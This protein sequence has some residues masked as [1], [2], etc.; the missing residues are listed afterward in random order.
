[1]EASPARVI[2][3]FNGEKQNLIPLF[4]RPYTW[5]ENNWQALWDDLMVQYEVGDTGTHFMGAIVSV[6][7]RSTP[8]G[9]NKYLII[10][11]QQRLTTVSLLLCALRDCLDLN[12]ASRIQEVYLTNRFRDLEDTLKFVPTQADRDV[13]R[14]IALDRQVPENSKDVRMAAAYH[15]FKNKLLKSTDLNDDRVDPVKVLTTLEQCLQ[16][17]M[18]NLGDD[19]DPYLIFESLNFKGEPLTQ[20]DLVRN[21]LLM[22]FR[23]SISTGGEQERVYSKYWVPL[24]SRLKSNLTEFLR[25]YTMKDGDDIKQGGIYAAIRTKLKTMDSTEA[26]EAEVQSM[27]RFGEFYAKFLSSAPEETAIIRDRLENIKEIKVTT[28]YPLLLRLFDARQTG[29]LSD[30]EL[31]KCLGLVES[32]VVRRSVC[33]V[34]TNPLN[35]LF[36]QLAKNFPDTEHEQWLL[37]TLSSPGGNRRFPKDA[38]F[39]AAFM[40][41]PQYGRGTTRFILCRLEKSFNHKEVVDLSTATIEH[42]LPQTLNQAWKDELGEEP[43]TVHNTL[44][45]TFG[46]LT[47]TGYNSELGNLPFSEKKSK[48]DTTHIELNRWI[49]Q[50]TNWGRAEIQERAKNL[51]LTAI[52]IWVSPSD[53]TIDSNIVI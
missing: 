8:V 18:I 32:F 52:K 28:S 21:Y 40:N 33:G 4:Q 49:L 11:G 45:N 31:D 19:D 6:P 36:I 15:F 37:R 41:Q 51:L 38:E 29:A 9:V 13:Y 16:V 1:M 35:K 2:Q 46:N 25:H 43:E 22:R 34:P 48:L 53:T 12:S 44:V 14:T 26:I 30:I 39:A 50:Q 10:D 5:T 27:Q 17:V 3:Y 7:A 24:E 42:V 23:H 20:A 47:L